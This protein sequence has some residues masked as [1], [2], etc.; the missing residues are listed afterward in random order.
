MEELLRCSR[1]LLKT[2]HKWS[3]LNLPRLCRHL[4]SLFWQAFLSGSPLVPHSVSPLLTIYL[5]LI[6]SEVQWCVSVTVLCFRRCSEGWEG[7]KRGTSLPWYIDT[8]SLLHPFSVSNEM[9]WFILVLF[10]DLFA[11][12]CTTRSPQ[13]RKHDTR[14][15]WWDE[16][17]SSIFQE[18]SLSY[19]IPLCK[20]HW[21]WKIE[22]M[23]IIISMNIQHRSYYSI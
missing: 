1:I 21:I 18:M 10:L 3:S 7:M 17:I 14:N 23:L 8:P 9:F 20:I 15:V 13:N 12:C 16:L 22:N 19:I 5:E 4:F 11:P 2:P 6:R